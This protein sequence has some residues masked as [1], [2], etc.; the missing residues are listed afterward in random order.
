M[1]SNDIDLQ[2]KH[3]SLEQRLKAVKDKNAP[4]GLNPNDLNLV[5]NLVI[6]S[7]FK[8]S[9]FKKYDGTSCPKMHLVM[10]SNKMTVH[11]YNEKLVIHIFQESL[12]EATSEWYLRLKKNQ[13]APRG[14]YF[15]HS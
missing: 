2:Q 12:T 7:H 15:E 13:L 11:A 10:Y 6:P 14:I 5:S 3:D 4:K 8:M 9:S 1:Q